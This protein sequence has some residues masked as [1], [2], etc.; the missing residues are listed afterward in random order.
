[1]WEMVLTR[2]CMWRTKVGFVKGH[3][4]ALGTCWPYFSLFYIP[5]WKGWPYRRLWIGLASALPILLWLP[6]FPSCKK[7]CLPLPWYT[8]WLGERP[9]ASCSIV[10]ISAG[11]A[12]FCS[13]SSRTMPYSCC[14]A[15]YPNFL[16]CIPPHVCQGLHLP[17]SDSWWIRA[18]LSA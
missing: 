10:K 3:V 2:G 14:W 18:N 1:M 5:K 6:I 8:R 11:P 15:H 13:F 12:S 4:K 9:E 17:A 7:R 16:P